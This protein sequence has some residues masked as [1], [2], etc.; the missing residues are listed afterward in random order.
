MSEA[1]RCPWCGK[2]RRHWSGW[3]QRTLS[4]EW[5]RLCNPCTTRRLNNPYSALLPMR[6]INVMEEA[7]DE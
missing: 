5:K 1:K 3:E 6:K 4:G 7:N 2:P